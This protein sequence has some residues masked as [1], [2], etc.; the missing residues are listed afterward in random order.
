MSIKKTV[1]QIRGYTLQGLVRATLLKLKGKELMISGS[2]KGC[3]SC[4]NKINL[5]TEKGWVR[6]QTEFEEVCSRYP[7]YKRFTVIGQDEQ[8]FLQFSCNWVTNEGFCEGYEN[9]LSICKKFPDKSLHFCG[10]GLPRQCGYSIDA[11]VPFDKVLQKEI[12][13]KR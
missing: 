4:C 10:G 3:G 1:K 2:C 5:E 11:V 13:R 9:R 8:G 12:G 7:E 6:N